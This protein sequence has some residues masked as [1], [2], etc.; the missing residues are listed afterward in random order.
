MIRC[1]HAQFAPR[2]GKAGRTAV[3]SKF[4]PVFSQGALI[5]LIA[6]LLGETTINFIDRQVVSVLAP[7]LRKEFSLSNGQYAA[8]VNAFMATYA[9]ALPIAGWC[10]IVWAWVAA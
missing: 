4:E 6:L 1:T 5:I 9:V 7:V 2:R 8:I 10:W 3:L